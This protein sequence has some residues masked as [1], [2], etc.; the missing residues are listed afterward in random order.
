GGA[1]AGIGA[2][3]LLVALYVT[4]SAGPER[5]LYFL[6]ESRIIVLVM[7]VPLAGAGIA[8]ALFNRWRSTP[9]I[10]PVEQ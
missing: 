1:L 7:A 6:N 3:L 5:W 2:T 9:A 10:A 4:M 8:A